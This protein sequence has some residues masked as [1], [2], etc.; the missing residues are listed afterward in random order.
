MKTV[1]DLLQAHYLGADDTALQLSVSVDLGFLR[2]QARIL[3]TL[4]LVASPASSTA[5]TKKPPTSAQPATS[6][7]PPTTT[8]RQSKASVDLVTA[9]IKA[10]H[11]TPASMAKHLG[12][13]RQ[14]VDRALSRYVKSGAVVRVAKGQY[15]VKG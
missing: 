13:E 8:T 12:L 14:L 2:Q 5:A 11:K 10:G 3:G 15:G 4:P 7:R 9:A 1:N 6:A